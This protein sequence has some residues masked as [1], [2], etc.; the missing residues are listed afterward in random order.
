MD[1]ELGALRDGYPALAAWI[2]RDPDNE[3][4]VFRKFERLAARNVLHLQARLIALEHE[5]NQQDEAARQS[6]DSKTRQS[7]RRWE[8][9]VECARDASR[10]ETKRLK[11]LDELKTLLKDYCTSES[12]TGVKSI[13]SQR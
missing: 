4:L 11:S 13:R 2:A 7:S 6:V 8:T 1:L 9:L 12:R 5:I 3:T 10:Q